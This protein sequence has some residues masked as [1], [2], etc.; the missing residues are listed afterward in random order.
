MSRF[1]AVSV[2]IFLFLSDTG[3]D[4]LRVWEDQFRRMNIC[5][6]IHGAWNALEGALD[7]SDAY[8]YS[9][10]DPSCEHLG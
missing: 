10:Q 4:G 5:L 3:C 8:L 2:Y 7:S 1:T 6:R 9:L